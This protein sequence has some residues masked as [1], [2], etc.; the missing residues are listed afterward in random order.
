MSEASQEEDLAKLGSYLP[1]GFT[2]KMFHPAIKAMGEAAD[3]QLKIS[4]AAFPTLMHEF[5]HL[6]Q[7]WPSFRGIMDFLNIW[8]QVGAVSQYVP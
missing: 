6:V 4:K 1:R 7:D 5:A 2:I 8:D 3:G